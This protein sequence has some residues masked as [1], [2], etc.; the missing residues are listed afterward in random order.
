MII[1][2]NKLSKIKKQNSNK[3]IVLTIGTFD[4]FHYEHLRYLQDAKKLGDILVVFVKSDKMAKEKSPSRPIIEGYQRMLIVDELKS[5]DY[6]VLCEKERTLKTVEKLFSK[7]DENTSKYLCKFSEYFEKLHPDILYH[8]DSKELQNG[9]DILAKKLNI[10][11]IKRPRT[12]IV[13]TTKIINK[14]KMS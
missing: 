14:I 12:A 4:L 11:L 9:R 5:V 7:Q 1:T 13:S 6:T 10:K 2:I 8:E 3:K